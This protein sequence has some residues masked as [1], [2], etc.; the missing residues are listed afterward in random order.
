MR[1]LC[2]SLLALALQAPLQ[3]QEVR[4]R[5]PA[6]DRVLRDGAP[7]RVTL[8]IAND[9]GKPV[10]G[11]QVG[12]HFQMDE[13]EGIV[14]PSDKDGRFVLQD[15]TRGEVRYSVN[16]S[17]YYKSRGTFKFTGVDGVLVK[18]GRWLPWNVEIPVT[19]RE[20]IKPIP[21]YA[22]EVEATVPIE[23]EF[24]GFD[25]EEGD[26]VAPHGS[27]DREDLRMSVSRTVRAP[28]DIEAWLRVS[29]PERL[30]GIV[31]EDSPFL[32]SAFI[33]QRHA[34]EGGYERSLTNHFGYN[35]KS[36]GFGMEG[37]QKPAVYYLR[38]RSK[39]DREGNLLEACYGKIY[40]EFEVIGAGRPGNPTIRF[41]YYLNP[42]PNDRNLEFDPKR[43][44]FKNLRS[45]ETV[46]EP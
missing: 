1:M 30:D 44:L 45:T 40:G 8:R 21:L 15:L 11:A 22:R 16:K 38:I 31:R 13:R 34:P 36:G 37:W 17:G 7:A 18:N 27:G 25:L 32:E 33:S 29:F 28:D 3:A 42:T 20:V 26:W 39:E 2:L 4:W 12:A 5:T 24:V 9:E 19:L 46:W 10:E 41:T 6:F 43:N 35:P 14:G 23:D